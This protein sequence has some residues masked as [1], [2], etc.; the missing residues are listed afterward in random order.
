MSIEICWL[1][2]AGVFATSLT[3]ASRC[4][5]ASSAAVV[6]FDRL[7]DDAVFE[8]L[9]LDPVRL[10]CLAA[11]S[12][13]LALCRMSR[14]RAHGAI[15]RPDGALYRRTCRRHDHPLWPEDPLRLRAHSWLAAN[16]ATLAATPGVAGVKA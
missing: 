13:S 1:R 14:R 12:V 9:M 7:I 5:F 10:A 15:A 4:V 16:A 6:R 2:C 8:S 11:R 3:T